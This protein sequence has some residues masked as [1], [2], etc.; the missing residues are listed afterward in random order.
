MNS[1]LTR[2]DVNFIVLKTSKKAIEF[3][4]TFTILFTELPSIYFN[5]NKFKIIVNFDSMSF[6]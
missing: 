2:I 4:E 6:C 1:F 5:E 3:A